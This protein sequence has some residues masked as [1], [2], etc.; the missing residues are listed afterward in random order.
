MKRTKLIIFA[1]VLI[2]LLLYFLNDEFNQY[3]KSTYNT[4]FNKDHEIES[5]Q[6]D[7]YKS[8][9]DHNYQRIRDQIIE[10]NIA[11]ED[12]DFILELFGYALQESFQR[13]LQLEF[14]SPLKVHDRIKKIN[15][16]QVIIEWTFSSQVE[17][18]EELKIRFKMDHIE[19]AWKV[20][21]KSLENDLWYL[22]ENR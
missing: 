8:I 4:T 9:K 11:N 14:D 13:T 6:R 20:N 22:Y 19:D 12:I 15:D 16:Q 5:A 3:A 18:S 10:T 2:G 17:E 21:L 7:F 1:L